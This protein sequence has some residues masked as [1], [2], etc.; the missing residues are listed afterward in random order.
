MDEKLKKKLLKFKDDEIYD[1][2]LEL[3]GAVMKALTLLASKDGRL[4]QAYMRVKLEEL[5]KTLSKADV[6]LLN[7]LNKRK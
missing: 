5:S 7:K 4:L 3:S 1:K 2:R 6:E